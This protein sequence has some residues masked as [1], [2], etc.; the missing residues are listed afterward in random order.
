MAM[1]CLVFLVAL[2]KRICLLLQ[3]PQVRSLGQVRSPGV[4]NGNPLQYSCQ[5]NPMHRGASW[6]YSPWGRKRVGQD[7][8]TKQHQQML[9]VSVFVP[10]YH[11]VVFHHMDGTQFVYP[12]T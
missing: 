5:E 12:F 4:G 9:H 8:V 3:E 6:G 1:L 7:L 2:W 10:F 11:R